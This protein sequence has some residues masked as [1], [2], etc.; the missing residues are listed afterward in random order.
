MVFDIGKKFIIIGLGLFGLIIIVDLV[1][2][3]M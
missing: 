3:R 2:F 1:F